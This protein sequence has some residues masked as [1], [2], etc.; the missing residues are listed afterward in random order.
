MTTKAE[1]RGFLSFKDRGARLVVKRPQGLV[2]YDLGR[3]TQA[4][5]IKRA[6][7]ENVPLLVDGRIFRRCS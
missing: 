2:N 4:E 3:I 5:A 7:V 1:W 6:H